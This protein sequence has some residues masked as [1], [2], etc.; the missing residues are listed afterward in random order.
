MNVREL[1]IYEEA[2]ALWLEVFGP[3]PPRGVDGSRMLE[4]ITS[5]LAEPGYE[6]LHSPHLRPS[7]ITHPKQDGGPA[8]P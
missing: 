1:R 2:V 4:I 5:H 6:R 3:P 7:A 8:R